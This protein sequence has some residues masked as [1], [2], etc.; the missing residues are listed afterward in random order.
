MN[1]SVNNNLSYKNKQLTAEDYL[2]R[3]KCI[4]ILKLMTHFQLYY[5]I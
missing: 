1:N 2:F 3:L 4:H 5:N